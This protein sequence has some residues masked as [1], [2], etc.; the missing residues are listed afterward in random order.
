MDS[1]GSCGS[2][3]DRVSL[4]ADAAEWDAAI[5]PVTGCEDAAVYVVWMKNGGTEG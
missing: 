3:R 1:Q 5:N 4:Y 2:T